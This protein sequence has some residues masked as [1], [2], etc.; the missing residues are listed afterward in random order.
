M[1]T[2]DDKSGGRSVNEDR[3]SPGESSDVNRK[4][5]EGSVGS[6]VKEGGGGRGRKLLEM[7]TTEE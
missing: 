5:R 7:K 6:E 4:V 3:N 1:R 2:P